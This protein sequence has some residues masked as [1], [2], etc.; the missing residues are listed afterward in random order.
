MPGTRKR[1]ETASLSELM[2]VGLAGTVVLSPA[3]R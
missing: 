3:R 1:A 2:A